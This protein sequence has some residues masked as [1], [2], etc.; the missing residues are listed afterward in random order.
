M[1]DAIP[2]SLRDVKCL[3]IGSTWTKKDIY[4]MYIYILDPQEEVGL[5]EH[6][7]NIPLLG[8]VVPLKATSPR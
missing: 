6:Q 7:Y 4:E 5:M 3:I 8:D 2:D 1:R